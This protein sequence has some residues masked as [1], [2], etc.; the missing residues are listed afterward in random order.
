VLVALVL[1]LLLL[2]LVL[3]PPVSSFHMM[4]QQMPHRQHQQHPTPPPRAL[5]PLPLPTLL[6]RWGMLALA[7]LGPAV[8]PTS[9]AQAF[10]AKGARLFED[11]CSSCHVG[12]SNIIGYAR[13]K[14]LKVSQ[15]SRPSQA[16]VDRS[17]SEWTEDMAARI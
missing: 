12:G 8:V 16:A 13:G 10:D 11:N 2:L 6:Q 5:L 4:Q 3:A 15:V 1:L 7:V 14:T 9:S 17:G